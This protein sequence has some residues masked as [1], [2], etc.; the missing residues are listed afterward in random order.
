MGHSHGGAA[1]SHGTDAESFPSDHDADQL[2]QSVATH[3]VED[4]KIDIL[5]IK[6]DEENFR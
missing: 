5:L 2:A 6:F 3:A 1:N 4:G